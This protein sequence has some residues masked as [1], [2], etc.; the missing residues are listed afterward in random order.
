MKHLFLLVISSLYFLN[1][2]SQEEGEADVGTP[3]IS[4]SDGNS[5]YGRVLDN[6]SSKGVASVS[7]QL[8]GGSAYDSLVGAMF[9]RPNGDFRFT[10][11]PKADSFKLIIS[12]VGF[13]N[14]ER[15]IAFNSDPAGLT[16]NVIQKDLGNVVLQQDVQTLGTVTVTAQ[17]P[18]MEMGIDRRV[19][20]V[21][22]S[23]TAT[24]GTAVD[25]MKNIPAVAVDVDGNVTLRNSS[26]QIFVDGRPTIL[27]LD[28]IPAN[29][30]E[31]VE[32]I[33][34]PSAKFDAASTGGII[35]VIMKRN[36]RV[37]LNGIASVGAGIPDVLNGNVSLNTRQNKFNFFLSGNYNQSGGETDRKT[38]RQNKVNGVADNYFNQFSINNRLRRFRSL[39]FGVDFFMD[40]RNTISATQG[41]VKGTFRNDEEQEQEFFNSS[42]VLE[43]YGD[44][45][46]EGRSGFERY[47]TQLNY[48]HKF[49]EQGKE[50]T[51]SV[52]YNYGNGENNSDIINRFFNPDG[53]EAPGGARVRNV[54][55]NNNNQLTFQVDFVNP[56]EEKSKL[57][58][59]IRSYINNY[60][61]F[62]SAYAADNGTETLLPLSNNIEY[63]EVVNAFYVTYSHNMKSFSYQAGLRAEHSDFDG[64]LLDDAKEFGYTYPDNID[65][66][67]DAL[68]PSLFLTKQLN[69]R[70]EMQLNYSRRIRRPNF[71]Q[72]N[73]F[74]DINDPLNI[75]QGNPEL[76]PEFTNSLEFNYSKRYNNGNLLSSVYYRNT[77]GDITSYSD[78]ISAEQYEQLNEAAIEPNAILNTF[79]NAQSMNRLGAEFTVQHRIGKNFDITPSINGEYQMVNA[80]IEGLDLSNEGFNW[81]AKLITNY[82]I[83]TQNPSFFNN[84][85]FQL[86]GEY[87]SPRIMPQGRQIPEYSVDFAMRKEFLK[88]KKASITFS[89]NDVFWTDRDG[90]IY[91]TETFYQETNRRNLRTFRLNFSYKFGDADFKLFNRNGA[92]GNDDDD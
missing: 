35:N 80:D 28:Q 79:I 19:F 54:G 55:S 88:N 75:S 91:D 69:D 87:E 43:R 86:I 6:K 83:T 38:F 18:A 30:I 78:T 32:L 68:F 70:E 11:L 81:E 47:N 1:G 36:K 46:S 24:G 25:V 57:E 45:F 40:N 56:K 48:T 22:Q 14:Q 20:N 76:R 10:N 27:T 62:F 5:V 65:R 89:V 12:A 39:R 26:P 49:P 52:N 17:R 2:W 33:T 41:I 9:T 8:Y 7:V 16:T 15:Y 42:K 50:L 31:R 71:W 21:D 3:V 82:R 23:L 59:G 37:G 72:L 64:R 34:N 92:N 90:A 66:L 60:Q 58:T 85:G 53:T 44:R 63:R 84:F 51:A 67:F 4:V 73:P 61:N 29:D 13:A 77:Q 74:V